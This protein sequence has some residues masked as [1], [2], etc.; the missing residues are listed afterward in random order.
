MHLTQGRRRPTW[1]AG[2]C[3]VRRGPTVESRQP[4]QSQGPAGVPSATLTHMAATVGIRALQQHASSVVARAA[5]GEEIE[6]TDRGRPVARIVALRTGRAASLIDAGRLRPAR[7]P[8]A[9]LPDLIRVPKGHP[10]ASSLLAEMRADE[11]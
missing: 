4:D 3:R 8:M 1:P 5:A 6:V 7:H 11:R 9:D 10:N 2:R